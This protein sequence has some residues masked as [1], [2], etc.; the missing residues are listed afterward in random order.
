M[1]DYRQGTH[2]QCKTQ[3]AQKDYRTLMILDPGSDYLGVEATVAG[4]AVNISEQQ[5]N[6]Y[7]EPEETRAF[8]DDEYQ[9]AIRR[10]RS[11]TYGTQKTGEPSYSTPVAETAPSSSW[12]TSV[13]PNSYDLSP[14]NV[15]LQLA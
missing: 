14:Y 2:P 13:D 15:K 10:S 1:S 11:E 8:D 7:D 4:I 9:E 12:S 6:G 5:V 3:L